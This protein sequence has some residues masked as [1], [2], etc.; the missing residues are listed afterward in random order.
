MKTGCSKSQKP[1]TQTKMDK[2]DSPL[3]GFVIA[4][5]ICII[6]WV[7]IYLLYVWIMTH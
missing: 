5:P 7:G 6:F 1:Q 3:R 2:E 4:A